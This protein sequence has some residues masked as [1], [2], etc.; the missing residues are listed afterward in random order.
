MVA[1]A[2]PHYFFDLQNDFEARDPEGKELPD[3]LTAIGEALKDARELLAASVKQDATIDLLHRIN[4]RGENGDALR[5][6]WF[7]DALTVRRGDWT[8][9]RPSSGA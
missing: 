4:V 1:G 8:I 7:E 6:V 5:T 9:S 2:V 3:L